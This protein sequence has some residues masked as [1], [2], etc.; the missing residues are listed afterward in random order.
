M[1]GGKAFGDLLTR[2]NDAR[3]DLQ[4]ARDQGVPSVEYSR[5]LRRYNELQDQVA[6]EMNLDPEH[7]KRYGKFYV[8]R[9]EDSD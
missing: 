2:R 9:T 6:W 8:G 5:L 1:L 7:V 4:W 3:R